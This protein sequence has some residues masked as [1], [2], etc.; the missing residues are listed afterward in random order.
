MHVQSHT[1]HECL[2]KD[3]TYYNSNHERSRITFEIASYHSLQFK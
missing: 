2:T 3:T 1:L